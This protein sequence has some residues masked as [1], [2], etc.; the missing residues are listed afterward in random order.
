MSG[1]AFLIIYAMQGHVSVD[2]GNVD[3]CKGGDRRGGHRDQANEI[4]KPRTKT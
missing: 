4:N 1:D 3:K 2:S